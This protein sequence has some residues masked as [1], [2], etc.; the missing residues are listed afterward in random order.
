MKS[1]KEMNIGE[2]AAYI[3]QYLKENG[4]LCTLTGGACVS[5]YSE[6]QYQSGDLDFIEDIS[7]PRKIIKKLMEDIGFV[8]HNRYF[9]NED[10]SWFIEFPTGPLSVGSEPV[11]EIID[12]QFSTGIL[13]IIS[14]TDCVKDR[15]AAYYF[16]DDKQSFEQALLVASNNSIDFEELKRWSQNEGVIEKFETFKSVAFSRNNKE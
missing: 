3:C 14:P 2:F 7:Y 4:I 10:I 1:M 11:K 12:M 8:E 5:I 15:L 16:W 9:I 13:K 6:N